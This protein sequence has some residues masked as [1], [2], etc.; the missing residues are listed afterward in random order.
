MT[1]LVERL[2]SQISRHH[3]VTVAGV[4]TLVHGVVYGAANRFPLR[5]PEVLPLSAADL[6]I[7]FI[8]ASVFVYVS[9]Y[10]LL[11]AALFL[12]RTP[13]AR[14]RFLVGFV[15]VLAST[16]LIHWAWPVAYPRELYPLVQELNPFTATIFSWVRQIDSP[17][18]CLPSLHVA[19][20]TLS[21]GALLL[22]GV[23]GRIG[24]SLWALAV[25]VSTL[26]TK[27]HF[28][29]DVVWGV[30]FGT[31]AALAIFPAPFTA[32]LRRG[33]GTDSRP[34]TAVAAWFR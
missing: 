2:A 34:R 30:V 11:F 5:T 8:P 29:V 14:A 20:A 6:W 3:V 21:V 26:T 28:V 24:I 9:D 32:S 15:G 23:P 16:T 18:S 4:A 33:S 12:L 22:E 25:C 19:A 17:A 31:A 27:Q 13:L 7:P 10:L 1:M